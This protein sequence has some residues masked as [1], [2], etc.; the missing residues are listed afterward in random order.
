M[1]AK[2]GAFTFVELV[3]GLT[4]I[5]VILLVLANLLR[6]TN[7]FSRGVVSREAAQEAALLA[8]RKIADKISEASAVNLPKHGKDTIPKMSSLLVFR[9]F[10]EELAF[11][12]LDKKRGVITLERAHLTQ[13]GKFRVLKKETVWKSK[14]FTSLLFSTVRGRGGGKRVQIALEAGEDWYIDNITLWN[15]GR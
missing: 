6:L 14:A 13:D 1:R 9:T 7:V 10:E 12:Y 8:V 2:K 3:V 11:L 4:L 5:S 15:A